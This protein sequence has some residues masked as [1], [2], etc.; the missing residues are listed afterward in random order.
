MKD[1]TCPSEIR[2]ERTWQ[3]G[4]QLDEGGFGRVFLAEDENGNKA[5][6]KLVP[7]APGSQREMLFV[8]LDGIPNVVPILD[9]GESDDYWALVMPQAEKSLRDYLEETSGLTTNEAISVLVDIAE[10][11]AAIES[12]GVVHRDIKPENILLLNDR[13]HI[14]DFGIARLA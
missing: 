12:R 6:V 2:L 10:A 9:S 8:D 5:V 14:A 1:R 4:P 3:L 7:Q 11:L 13:W